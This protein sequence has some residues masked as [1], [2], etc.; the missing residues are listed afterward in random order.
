MCVECV[1]ELYGYWLSTSFLMQVDVC[2]HHHR[3]IEV[4]DD[5]R[6]TAKKLP[7]ALGRVVLT[8]TRMQTRV[9]VSLCGGLGGCVCVRFVVCLCCV[10]CFR[11]RACVRVC[12]CAR[13]C[14][15]EALATRAVRCAAHPLLLRCLPQQKQRGS[16]SEIEGQDS[17]IVDVKI[18]RA[19]N[20]LSMDPNGLCVCVC[21]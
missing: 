7:S 16:K 3:S 8:V 17:R 2:N 9:G 21:D 4:I 10:F 13:V 14:D 19:K 1:C 5:G 20:L 18:L 12:A 15:V 6:K 11:R